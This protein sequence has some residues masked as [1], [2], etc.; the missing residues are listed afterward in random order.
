MAMPDTTPRPP[1]DYS[2]FLATEEPMLIVG[3]QAVNL[4]ALYYHEATVELAPFVS[5]D[6]DILGDRETLQAI[7]KVA[8]LKPQYFPLTPPSNEV[9]YIMPKDDSK[10]PLLIEVLRWVNGVTADDIFKDAVSFT[11]GTG[12]VTVKVPSPITLLQAKIANLTTIPQDGRQ[13]AKH[14]R[15]LF[16]VIPC[17]L[18]DLVNTVRDGQR[19][20]RELVNMLGQLLE[21]VATEQSGKAIATLGLDPAVLFSTLSAKGFYKVAAFK[22]HQL[23]RL[24]ST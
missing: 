17:Y 9:G 15:I 24:N 13:D 23:P 20:E 4:W 6:V 11:I 2:R 1:E 5:R 16:C 18:N 19:T 7:A 14:V 12:Q 22:K 8:K 21:V 10:I 3:G